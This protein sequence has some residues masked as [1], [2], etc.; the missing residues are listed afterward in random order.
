VIARKTRKWLKVSVLCD[1][2]LAALRFVPDA[3]LMIVASSYGGD[4]IAIC[5]EGDC[6]PA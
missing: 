1:E 5:R 6:R 2:W 3:T 4:L